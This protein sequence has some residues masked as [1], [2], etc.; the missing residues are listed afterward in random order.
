MKPPISTFKDLSC[1]KTPPSLA[2]IVEQVLNE[3][4][5][6]Y[7]VAHDLAAEIALY[8]RYVQVAAPGTLI[9]GY[10]FHNA[11]PK[12]L[13]N[14][15]TLTKMREQAQKKAAIPLLVDCDNKLAAQGYSAKV[16]FEQ[17][18]VLE[19]ALK[20]NTLL[21]SQEMLTQQKLHKLI[22]TLF[23]K[24]A[25]LILQAK[26]KSDLRQ[27][28]SQIFTKAL[29]ADLE[30]VALAVNIIKQQYNSF[31]ETAFF[32]NFYAR[33]DLSAKSDFVDE[34]CHYLD[35]KG[36]YHGKL[37][38]T[39]SSLL[40]LIPAKAYKAC[41]AKQFRLI[42]DP[43]MTV[44]E[45]NAEMDEWANSAW[46]RYT[47]TELKEELTE[48]LE[49]NQEWLEAWEQ[50]SDQ[51]RKG[52]PTPKPAFEVYCF[53]YATGDP[54]ADPRRY[55]AHNNAAPAIDRP[56]T[57]IPEA[58]AMIDHEMPYEQMAALTF[59]DVPTKTKPRSRSF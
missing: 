37:E 17:A 28:I 8:I 50:L 9:S 54:N 32:D 31:L 42:D 6:E 5:K 20:S 38:A 1:Q 51:K 46:L 27:T 11:L 29:Y 25:E 23:P 12:E 15:F 41:R 3:Y 24:F 13:T 53:R 49:S 26:E 39:L 14:F 58:L 57:P 48:L 33:K 18:C 44:P 40:Y 2:K 7:Q 45:V 21:E 52:S 19:K 35:E 47:G 34:Y 4:L 36:T 16:T 55:L 30:K 22:E 56:G 10:S 59:D 43:T